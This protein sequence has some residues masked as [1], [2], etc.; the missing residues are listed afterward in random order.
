MDIGSKAKFCEVRCING[1]HLL[2]MPDGQRVPNVVWT[3]VF[4]KFDEPHAVATIQIIVNIR[5]SK[6]GEGGFDL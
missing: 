5:E 4:D 6:A 2:F 3:R 1:E